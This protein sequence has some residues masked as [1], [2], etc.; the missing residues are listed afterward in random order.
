MEDYFLLRFANHI[1]WQVTRSLFLYRKMIHTVV[2]HK[3][4][5]RSTPSPHVVYVVETKSINGEESIYRRYSDA[6]FFHL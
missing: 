3:H 5:T 1:N 2:V 6:R 4:T